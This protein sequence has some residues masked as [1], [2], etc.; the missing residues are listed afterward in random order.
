MCGK[1]SIFHLLG[2]SEKFY[3]VVCGISSFLA[4][5]RADFSSY[6]LIALSH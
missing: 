6:R 2:L 1:K 3:S 5:A 4:G